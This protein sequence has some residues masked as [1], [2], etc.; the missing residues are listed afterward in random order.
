MENLITCSRVL[1][2]KDAKDKM[3]EITS[4]KR[5]ITSLKREML[6]YEIPKIEYS[7]LEEWK[8]TRKDAYQIIKNGLNECIIEDTYEY[9]YMSY[10]GLTPGQKINIR[11][12]IE[13]A[14]KIITKENNKEWVEKITDAII[15]GIVGF[16]NGFIKTGNGQ[17]IYSQLDPETMSNLIYNNIIWQLDDGEHYPSMLDSIA[18]F[19]C[20]MCGKKK[21]YINDDNV[22]FICDGNI[23][24]YKI[25]LY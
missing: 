8:R 1:Y 6:F 12:Y 2:D 15:Y 22:C 3:K 21:H 5:E 16:L 9:H 23:N 7:N 13:Q 18:I 4:L 17:S 19:T 24:E 10:L 11:Y 14:L 25:S 20:K